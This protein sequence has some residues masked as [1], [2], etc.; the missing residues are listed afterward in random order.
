M[1]N[2]NT[3]GEDQ[4]KDLEKDIQQATE[5]SQAP[6]S[7]VGTEEGFPGQEPVVDSET[8]GEEE[9]APDEIPEK[10]G[11]SKVGRFFRQLLIWLVVIAIAFGAGIGTFYY[12]RFQP[13]QERLEQQSQDI[14]GAEEEISTQ[15]DEI[16]RLSGF[17]DRNQELQEEIDRTR[18][19]IT[20]LSA[21]S[22]VSDA[23]LALS[24]DNLAEAKLELDKVGT[25]LDKL[26]T[27]LN[28]DQVDVVKN[29]QQRHDL[30]MEE[31]EQDTFS[32]RSD[33]EVLS[34]KLGSLENTLFATP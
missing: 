28:E 30:I 20:L 32:A 5:G 26:E 7:D 17:E 31:L 23:L 27:M 2:K 18:L 19:H 12:L 8:T 25:T 14:Q 1:E 6:S 34:S 24:E 3:S 9:S 13:M 11:P 33:L 21:R 29:L 16:E 15:E 4:Q 22:S 10:K